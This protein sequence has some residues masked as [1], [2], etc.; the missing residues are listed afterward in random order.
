MQN[1]RKVY[2]ETLVE[3]GRQNQRIVALDADLSK[4]TMTRFFE[5]EFPDRFFEMGIGALRPNPRKRLH[6]K[7]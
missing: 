6:R 4:S 1:C 2:G 3:L 5:H 7:S